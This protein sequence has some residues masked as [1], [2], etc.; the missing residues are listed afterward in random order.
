MSKPAK[1][2]QEQL[3]RLKER[4]LLIPDEAFALHILQHHN[5]YRLSAYRFPFVESEDRDRFLPG[6]TFTQ[7]WDLYHF[8]RSL[9][10]LVLE[11]CKRVEISA[12]SRWAYEIGHQVSPLAY[13]D[14]ANFHDADI[15]SDTLQ[16]LKEEMDR[17]KE[18]YIRHHRETLLMP[19]PPAW[20]IAEVASFGN[21]SNLIG[22]LRDPSLRQAIADSYELDEKTFCSLLH[23]LTILRNTAA[24]HSL[25]WN[26]RFV[27]RFKLPKKKPAYLY[28]NFSILKKGSN[29]ARIHNSLILLIHFLRCIEPE[30][31][32]P[33]RLL[34]T[35]QTLDP[36]LLPQMGFLPDWQTRPMWQELLTQKQ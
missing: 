14:P 18:E 2:Y 25:L 22:Q 21:T 9:R 11:A 5:Y 20:V 3:D 24:H 17:S 10:Q 26:R 28:P 6:T 4:G 29:S 19:W 7:L 23:H 15:H 8:D 30:T 33:V 32:W 35:I 31:H 36:A 16:K 34:S 1:T 27:V 12:R 13:T